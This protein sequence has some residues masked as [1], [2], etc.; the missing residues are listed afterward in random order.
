MLYYKQPN[1]VEGSNNSDIRE[2][3]SVDDIDIVILESFPVQVN[4][5]ARG[6]LPD[7]CT[8]IDNVTVNREGNTFMVTITT[9]RPARAVCAQVIMPFEEVVS[10]DVIGLEAGTYTI[11]VN[12]V[13][14]TFQLQVDNILD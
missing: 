4:V 7:A 10:L 11:N 6:N 14:G 1:S 12:G 5:I 2:L 9:L 13:T 3:A 8:R